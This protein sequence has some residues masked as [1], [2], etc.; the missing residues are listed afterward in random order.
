M[1]DRALYFKLLRRFRHDH[2]RT[3][4]LIR[5]VF[6]AVD[7]AGARLRVKT[8]KGAA[9]MIGAAQVYAGPR[10]WKRRCGPRRPSRCSSS[11]TWNLHNINS[12]VPSAR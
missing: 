6:A 10:C 3:L 1:G 11:P 5:M 7:Y 12:F 2:G 8:L 4:P 9:G